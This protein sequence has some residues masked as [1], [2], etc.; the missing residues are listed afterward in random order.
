MIDFKELYAARDLV[1]FLVFKNL[2]GKYAQ[3]ILG[4]LWAV[5][6]PLVQTLVFTVI[7]GKLANLES[8]G[9]P[10]IFFS[11]VA[12]VPWNYFSNV[13]GGATNSLVG[14]KA[15][16]SKVYFPRLVLP[17]SIVFAQLLDF[18]VSF[19]IMIGILVFNGFYPDWHIFMIVPLWF[20]MVLT[21][22]GL[23][24]L[25]ASLS[26]RYRDVGYII[27]LLNK[28]LMYSAPVVYSL[29]II[30][31]KYY[32]LYTCNPM[33]G[34]IEGMRSIF[35]QTNPFP[36]EIVLRGGVVAVLIFILGTLYF[37]KVEK[38]IADIA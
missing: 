38:S 28:L 34:V 12:M 18:L 2:K 14:N 10:Y 24:N 5:V 22:L 36:W 23:G 16:L 35:L 33:V 25:L 6:Q 26:I 21:A 7:F 11:F 30:P 8:D 20:I 27:G 4:I 15:I 29:K 17:I 32:F 13:L 3:S 19:I 31:E 1:Y 37:K 9:S